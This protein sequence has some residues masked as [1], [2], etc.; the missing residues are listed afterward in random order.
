MLEL[1]G[2]PDH[3]VTFADHEQWVRDEILPTHV[4]LWFGSARQLSGTATAGRPLDIR[5][6]E[7]GGT[8]WIFTIIMGHLVLVAL[9]GPPDVDGFDLTSAS[10]S[11]HADLAQTTLDRTISSEDEANASPG[12]T[13]PPPSAAVHTIHTSRASPL[14]GDHHLTLTATRQQRTVARRQRP[15]SQNAR[16]TL[17]RTIAAGAA[18]LRDQDPALAAQFA[19]TAYRTADTVEARSALLDSSAL[20]LPRRRPGGPPSPPGLICWQARPSP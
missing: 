6:G 10:R 3:R 8:G 2:H 20:L 9:A 17:S 19:L 12:V 7:R 13:H 16:R 1:A 15:T 11:A 18:R 4:S 14:I 5:V